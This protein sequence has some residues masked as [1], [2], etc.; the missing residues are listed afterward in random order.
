[1]TIK[2]KIQMNSAVR[3]KRVKFAGVKVYKKLDFNESINRNV[4]D[5][6]LTRVAQET[7]GDL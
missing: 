5:E 3:D 2:Q 1:M 4:L 6:V 7:K